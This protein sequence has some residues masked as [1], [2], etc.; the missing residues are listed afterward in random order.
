[1]FRIDACKRCVLDEPDEPI[2]DWSGVVLALRCV[3][4][5]IKGQVVKVRERK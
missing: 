5:G 2:V 4:E 3:V 1:M